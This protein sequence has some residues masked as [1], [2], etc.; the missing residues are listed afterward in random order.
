[1]RRFIPAF[2]LATLC[3]LPA[4]ARV[5]VFWQPGFPT[6]ASQP[7]DRDTLAKALEGMEPAFDGL[8]QLQDPA[9][10]LGADLL[11][12]PYGSAAP[13]DAWDAILNYLRSGGNLLVLGG[14]PLRVPVT[15]MDGRFVEG[16]PQDSYARD[17]NLQHTYEVPS[18]QGARFVWRAGYSF[19]PAPAVRARRFFAVE[20]RLNGLGYMVDSDGVEVAAPVIVSDHRAP[21]RPG[22]P[23]GGRRGGGDMTPGGRTVMLDFEPEPGYWASAD[24]LSLI[25]Q[26]AEYARQGATEF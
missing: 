16:R 10:L 3:V 8:E 26:S 20:G 5:V 17:L 2:L 19:L 11:V 9:A 7:A 25:R 18:P 12:L 1:M 13:A 22:C 24:G 6:I 4:A 23:G 14:Q 15:R 21:E